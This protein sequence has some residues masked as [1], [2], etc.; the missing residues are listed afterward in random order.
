MGQPNS[1]SFDIQFSLC[2]Y[3]RSQRWPR[4]K[5]TR[6]ALCRR[7]GFRR[8]SGFSRCSL[9]YREHLSQG[10]VDLM[11]HSGVRV[12]TRLQELRLIEVFAGLERACSDILGQSSRRKLL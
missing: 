4:I 3:W 5:R 12:Y 9:L 8:D 1:F 11:R 6:L 7:S 2:C 10:F